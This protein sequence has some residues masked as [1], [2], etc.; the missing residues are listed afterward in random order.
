MKKSGIL[1]IVKMFNV[2]NIYLAYFKP[3]AYYILSLKF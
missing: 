3:K 2:Y 1:I